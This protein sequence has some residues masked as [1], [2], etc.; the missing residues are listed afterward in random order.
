MLQHFGV[1]WSA[2]MKMWRLATG[3]P[4]DGASGGVEELIRT[5]RQMRAINHPAA[6]LVMS[7]AQGRGDGLD[8]RLQRAIRRVHHLLVVLHQ[9]APA[10]RRVVRI[11]VVDQGI[12]IPAGERDKVFEKFYR[13]EGA[14]AGGSG[15]GLAIARRVVEDHGGTITIGGAAPQGTSVEIVLPQQRGRAD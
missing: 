8:L 7:A 10:E 3:T 1:V 5:H 13:V 15:L 14:P 12:G 2:Q 9:D 11:A 4:I 6:R